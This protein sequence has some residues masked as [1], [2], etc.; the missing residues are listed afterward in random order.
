MVQP[1]HDFNLFV[2]DIGW[3]NYYVPDPDWKINII[4]QRH[5]IIACCTEGKAQYT[6]DD[7]HYN[8]QKGDILFFPKHKL[9]IGSSDPKEP[10]AFYVILFDTLF[11]DEESE[12]R[13]FTF[14][15]VITN[16]NVPHLFSIFKEA[17][18]EWTTK[19]SGYLLRC[20]SKV[21][22][23]FSLLIRRLD[24]PS[25]NARHSQVI[26]EVM[27]FM[28][29]NY[30]ISFTIE[31]LCQRAGY[32][33]SHF[34]LVFKKL[35]GKTIIQYQN[36]IK[37]LKARDLLQYGHCNVSEAALQVGFTDI[38]YFSKLFK[39]IIGHNPSKFIT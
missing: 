1:K 30:H 11:P 39:K 8:V 28:A 33:P 38:Y 22:E 37:I 23:A 10:W 19:K 26:D 24:F 6:I 5:H 36:E 4:N 35:T 31:E 27:N 25:G 29:D 2:T 15:N 32:S 21:L 13:F 20:R 9:H 7:I 18:L 3:V 16:P 34:Q 14:D 12:Q 17:H